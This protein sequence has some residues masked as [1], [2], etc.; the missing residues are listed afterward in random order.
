M[1]ATSIIITIISLFHSGSAHATEGFLQTCSNFTL[2]D[3]NGVKGRSPI[4]TATCKTIDQNT[5]WSELN[6][7]NCLGWSAVDCR[8]I[9]PPSGGFTD[10]VTGCNNTFYGGDEHFG[11]NFGCYGPCVASDPD[12]YYDVFILNS[13]IGNTDGS[14]S[15]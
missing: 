1:K 15:C 13:V 9:F 8:F 2:R 3:L 6:L 12:E 7:N 5:N 14:L 11:E 4:L 10:S